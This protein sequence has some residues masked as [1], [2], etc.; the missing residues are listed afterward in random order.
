MYTN[1]LKQGKIFSLNTIK[2]PSKKVFDYRID[3]LIGLALAIAIAIATYFGTYQI[4]DPIFTDIYVQDVWFGSDIPT[5]FG[6]I[7][8]FNSDFGR[9][10]KHPLFPLFVF[11]LVFAIAKLLQLDSLSAVRVVIICVAILWICSLYFLFRLMGCYRLDATL[12]SLLGAVSAASIFWLVIPESFSFGSLTIILGLAFV[13]LSQYRP[14]SSVWYLA[15]NIMTVS[16]TITNWMV[17]ILATVV[18]HRWKKIFQILIVSL[19]LA[20]GLWII[21]RIVF[22]NSGF[23]FQP[24]TFIGEKKFMSAPSSK[25]ILAVISSFFYQTMVMP[26]TRLV[27]SPIRP[28]WV[29]FNVDTLAPGSGSSW[30]TVAILTW[31]GLLC[32][33]IWGFF[34]TKKHPKLRIVLGLTLVGQLLIHSVYGAEETFIYSLHFI[35]L[36]LTLTVFSLFTPL[37]PLSL[38]LAIILIF[39]A[40]ITNKT[41][42]NAIASSLWNYGTPHQ[43]VEAQMK[44]RPADLWPRSTG[45]VILASPGSLLE[46]KAFHEPGGSFSPQPGSF[47]VSVWVVDSRGNLK[48]TSDNIPLSE[49]QQQLIDLSAEKTPGIL[50]KTAYYETSWSSP[51]VGSWKLNLRPITNENK[52][53]VVIRS[54]GPAGGAIPSLDWDGQRLLISDRW[55]VT[56]LSKTAKVYLGSENT[57]DWQRERANRSHWND[58]YGWSYARLELDRQDSWNLVIEDNQSISE[59]NLDSTK[60]ASSL[61]LDLPDQQFTQSLEAQ[62]AHLLM[63]LVGTRTHP[64]D[65]ISYP[66]TRYRDGAYQMVA[67]TRAGQLDIAKKLS[68]YFAENDWFNSTVPE[69]DIPAVGIWALEEVAIALQEPDYD[70][71]LWPHIRRKAELIENMLSSNRPGYPVLTGTKFPF[72]ESP[73]FMRVDLTAG[74]LKSDNTPYLISLNPA[75]SVMSYRAL[76]DAATLAERLKQIDDAQHWRSQAEQLKTAWQEAKKRDFSSFPKGLWSSWIDDS[77]PSL[78]TQALQQSWEESRDSKGAFLQAPQSLNTAIAEAHQWLM[79]ERPERVWATLKWFWQNQASPG[80]YTWGDHLNQPNENPIPKSFSKW[81]RFRGWLNPSSLTPHYWTSAE[82]LLLQ[83]DMLTYVDHSATSPTLIIGAGMPSEWLEQPISVKEQLVEGNLINWTWDGKQVN[84]EIQGETMNVKVGSVFPTE[85]P[86]NIKILPKT[87]ALK[88]I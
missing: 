69:A 52:L 14:F 88:S 21:Q 28:D 84:V 81:H 29:K 63:G 85:T 66:L 13:V 72:S 86:V 58:P 2:L 74:K 67:L 44:L 35:P 27:D 26:A 76:N 61:V 80:L 8:S 41:Q 1:W 11:P 60:I 38:V 32:L 59:P 82:M 3:I 39:S 79:L 53:I 40:G 12:F 78:I 43:Q 34:S 62:V 87:K 73:D 33:G 15:V 65:P 36:L 46:N 47:G 18:N 70:Q 56:G 45:H 16:I 7:T 20:T 64:S 30:G 49:I 71:W 48:A 77:E 17:G 5:V 55:K 6:N 24:G 57:K 50:T 42:F 9:N 25:S 83:L 75:A 51:K 4:P 10:N 23:P 19:L 22:T 68:T 31:T 37:R 54:V